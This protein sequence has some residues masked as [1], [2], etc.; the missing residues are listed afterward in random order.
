VATWIGFLRAIN[1][2]P[3]RKFPKEAIISAVE[4]AG[5]TDV[6][7]HIN[8]GN[9]RFDTSLRSRAKI[10]TALEKAFRA[11]AGFD[12]PTIVFTQKELREIAEHAESFGHTGRHY[13]SLLKEAPSSAA[14]KRLEESIKTDEVAKVGGRAV[15]LLIGGNYHE[16]TLTNVA[17]EKYLG[18]ATN[19][20]VTVIRTI[21]QKWC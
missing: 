13:V 5:F 6:A 4:A 12:V 11:E 18:V 21:T 1:L 8:T 3:T 7:T 14:I 10:E 15:H 16:A 20:N 2:G 19:R 9:V 17:V